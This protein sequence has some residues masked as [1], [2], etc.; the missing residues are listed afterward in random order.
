MGGVART[1]NR[2]RAEGVPQGAA[3]EFQPRDLDG[4]DR[5]G[6][7]LHPLRGKA[8]QHQAPPLPNPGRATHA[9]RRAASDPSPAY[10]LQQAAGRAQRAQLAS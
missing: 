3:D 8:V 5:G 4:G 1:P 2:V 10:A 6:Q 7:P 9:S